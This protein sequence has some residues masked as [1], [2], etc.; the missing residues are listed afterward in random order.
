MTKRRRKPLAYARGSD[1]KHRSIFPAS[2]LSFLFS[3]FS[4]T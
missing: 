2:L 1:G 4:L 3:H